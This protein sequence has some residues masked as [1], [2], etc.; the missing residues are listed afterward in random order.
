MRLTTYDNISG[1]HQHIFVSSHFD[2]V[3]YSCGGTLEALARTGARPLVVTVYASAPGPEM[4]LREEALSIHKIM[5]LPETT[6][7]QEVVEIRRLEDAAACEHLHSDYLWLHYYDKIYRATPFASDERKIPQI[8]PDDRWIET[9][10]AQELLTVQQRHPDAIWYFP[11]ATGHH[12]D[13]LSVYEAGA[14]LEQ[15]GATVYYYE[16]F[17]YALRAAPLSLEDRMSELKRSFTP[18]LVDITETLT[19]KV[20]ASS[21]YSSQ[22]FMNFGSQE[23][24]VEQTTTYPRT[25]KPESGRCYE[26]YWQPAK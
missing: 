14:L 15:S 18:M 8:H 12:V 9:Q 10:L 16:D 2:D 21:M 7:A 26:R 13:H 24:L 1:H 4:P 25:I 6:P 23:Q 5:S 22:T 19:C 3:V 11:L 20:E 17:P